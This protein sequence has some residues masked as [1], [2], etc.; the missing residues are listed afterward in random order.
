[1]D[2]LKAVQLEQ[3]LK[4]SI[5]SWEILDLKNFGKSA[6]VFRVSDGTNHAALKV[7]D[8]ELIEKYGDNTNARKC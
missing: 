2:G 6:A 5:G 3:T 1:M 4:G 7:F 8:D